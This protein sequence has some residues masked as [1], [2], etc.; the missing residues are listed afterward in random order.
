[1]AN[2]IYVTEAEVA[3]LLDM[4]GAIDALEAVFLAQAHGQAR[5]SPRQRA[6]YWGGRLNLMSAGQDSGRFAFKAY[7]GTAAPTVY[8]VMLYDAREGLI[9]IIEAGVLGQLRTGAATGVATRHMAAK[10]A[11]T[12]GMIGAGKHARTQLQAIQAVRPLR[13]ANVFSRDATRLR[14]FCHTMSRE[15]SIDVAPAPG[16]E[17]ALHGADIVVTATTSA[18]PVIA[19][20]WLVAGVHV[21]AMGANS[22]KRNELEAASYAR[23]GVVV[24]DDVAQARLEAGELIATVRDGHKSWADF[25]ELSSVVAHGCPPSHGGLTIFKSLGAALEDLAAANAIYERASAA[26]HKRRVQ[27]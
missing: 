22:L 2:P 15:L 16:A 26:G 27:G 21:N 25:H 1:M 12:L 6:E 13:R 4:R 3:E 7:A 11:A 9:A 23:A 17:S 20:A 5:N 10:S 8:H 24:T 19:D 18:K 14:D